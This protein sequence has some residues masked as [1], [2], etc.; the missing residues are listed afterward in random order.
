MAAALKSKLAALTTD[1][2]V[3]AGTAR[4]YIAKNPQTAGT[5]RQSKT[6]LTNLL[7]LTEE[8]KRTSVSY[9]EKVA[10]ADKQA[11]Q[12][13]I[14][15]FLQELDVAN[16]DLQE[17]FQ[18][19]TDGDEDFRLAQNPRGTAMY[20]AFSKKVDSLDAQLVKLKTDMEGENQELTQVR[21]Q[22]YINAVERIKTTLEKDLAKASSDV[23]E[24][25]KNLNATE[26]NKLHAYGIVLQDKIQQVTDQLSKLSLPPS[27]SLPITSTPNSSFIIAPLQQTGAAAGTAPL[28]HQALPGAQSLPP[29]GLSTAST[30]PQGYGCNG[31]Y[32]P[33]KDHNYP[34][35]KGTVEEY[36]GWKREWQTRIL[37]WMQPDVAHLLRCQDIQLFV[38]IEFY[39]AKTPCQYD[40]KEILRQLESL[41]GLNFLR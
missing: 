7:Q 11:E 16:S 37:P 9:L 31:Y 3:K 1:I 6:H 41:R 38:G 21:A 24:T 27:I 23:K 12:T 25:H 26:L 22:L 13:R 39:L 19:N 20:K 30:H 15:A 17:N 32:K 40:K 34:H 8:Y 14:T 2:N 5:K 10:P 18:T 33:Y 35:F 4:N 28:P 36:G 29:P